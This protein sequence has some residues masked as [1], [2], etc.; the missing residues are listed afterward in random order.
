MKKHWVGICIGVIALVAIIYVIWDSNQFGG[1]GPNI[2]TVEDPKVEPND[3][4]PYKSI[5]PEDSLHVL[6]VVW[7]EK[8]G[9]TK[10]EYCMAVF[11]NDK[12]KQYKLVAPWKEVTDI[13]RSNMT[14]ISISTVAKKDMPVNIQE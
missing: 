11:S 14:D 6:K 9:P 5:G 7:T 13:E 2:M 10:T 12:T 8:Y 4:Q 1:L 3:W